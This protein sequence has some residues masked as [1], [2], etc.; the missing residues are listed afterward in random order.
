[1]VG[2]RKIGGI[3]L[4]TADGKPTT[5]VAGIGI[6]V[7][8][9]IASYPAELQASATTAIDETGGRTDLEQLAT[10][11]LRGFHRRLTD[12]SKL[13]DEYV[14]HLYGVGRIVNVQGTIGVF[15]G[16]GDDGRA[17]VSRDG[18]IERFYSGPMQLLDTR[19]GR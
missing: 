3:L 15:E 13:Q 16:V 11:L 4:E 9:P 12:D 14:E 6:N 5:V 7:N 18:A 1:M 19:N 10:D 2:D 8:V 17:R